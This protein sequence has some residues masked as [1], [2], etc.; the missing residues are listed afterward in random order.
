M[1]EDRYKDAD[2]IS[3]YQLNLVQNTGKTRRK[4]TMKHYIL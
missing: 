1:V 4:N 3:Q 2:N